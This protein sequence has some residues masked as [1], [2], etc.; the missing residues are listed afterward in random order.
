M[1]NTLS[2]VNEA[3]SIKT[4]YS[5]AITPKKTTSIHA[6]QYIARQLYNADQLFSNIVTKTIC[7]TNI[8][9]IEGLYNLFAQDLPQFTEVTPNPAEF[10]HFVHNLLC[11]T[12]ILNESHTVIQADIPL[13][14]YFRFED[15]SIHTV[16]C[17]YI[18][19]ATCVV[20]LD[21]SNRSFH[22]HLL[23]IF[24]IAKHALDALIKR[25]LDTYNK[26]YYP[27]YETLRIARMN[28]GSIIRM[29]LI[30]REHRVF[31]LHKEIVEYARPMICPDLLIAFT[32]GYGI[33]PIDTYN[34]FDFI[35]SEH[36]IC[37]FSEPLYRYYQ[38]LSKDLEAAANIDYELFMAK[39][40]N[41]LFARIDKFNVT[42]FNGIITA[43]K[44][45][46]DDELIGNGNK[47]SE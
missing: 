18:F 29:R 3:S 38:K 4:E 30:A 45:V 27:N 26:L 9:V 12:N 1:N 33:V 14:E 15:Y 31:R 32:R 8:T 13:K 11:F 16:Y 21:H 19:M 5:S 28:K 37:C 36:D 35:Y 10:N 20:P 43:S 41:H 34:L 23:L 47:M 17:I 44:K 7:G 25:S 2:E 40:H 6:K 46:E 42:E 24:V 39:M 22:E